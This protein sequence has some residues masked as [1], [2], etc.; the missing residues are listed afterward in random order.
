M[1]EK[2]ETKKGIVINL[3]ETYGF[4]RMEDGEDIFFHKNGTI[5]PNFEDLREGEEVEFMVVKIHKDMKSPKAI[6]VVRVLSN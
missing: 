3:K 4:I 6:G 5:S 2:L 1:C